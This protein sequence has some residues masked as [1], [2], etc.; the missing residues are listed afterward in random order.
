VRSIQSFFAR[1]SRI[2]RPQERGA[3]AVEMALC[4]L[5]LLTLALG[6][7]E[8]GLLMTT[9][10][11]LN[12]ATRLAGRVASSPCATTGSSTLKGIL[13]DPTIAA[14]TS[15]PDN[16]PRS[17][18]C[19]DS[20]NT[21]FD[22][23]YI[24]RSIESGLG[25]K[26]ADVEKIII[27]K[28]IDN[29]QVGIGRVPQNCLDTDL[30]VQ[31]VCNVYTKDTPLLGGATGTKLL[32]NLDNF[33][34]QSGDQ[35]GALIGQKLV[36]N[37]GCG[38]T[39]P[40]SSKT[41][42]SYPFCPTRT[43]SITVGAGTKNVPVRLRN[44]A[45]P[46]PLGIY[47]KLK[48]QFVTGFFRDTQT[49]SD[50]TVFRL[51]PSPKVN[52]TQKDPCSGS[53]PPPGCA[54]YPQIKVT[55]NSITEGDIPDPTPPNCVEVKVT[56]SPPQT[57]AQSVRLKTVNGTAKAGTDYKTKTVPLTFAANETE[58][59]VCI[60]I[61]GDTKFEPEES[62]DVEID[63]PSAGLL[64]GSGLLQGSL[65]ANIK[66]IDNDAAPTLSI[67]DIAAIDEGDEG[68]FTV[69]LS[70]V[71]DQDTT[72][73]YFTEDGT[74]LLSNNDYDG[75]AAKT[76]TIPAN[77]TSVKIK[78]KANNDAVT[79]DNENFVVKIS[80]PSANAALGSKKD[81]T[82][83]IKDKTIFLNIDN[84]ISINEGQ[85]GTF[86]VKI[87]K[88]SATNVT[89]TWSTADGA[90][91][92]P[93]ANAVAPGDY[94]QVT[95]GTGT[96]TAGSQSTTI[97][98]QTKNDNV[99]ENT[100][101]KFTVTLA[102]PVGAVLGADKTREAKIVDA[103]PDISISSIASLDEGAVG[104]IT[105]SLNKIATVDVYFSYVAE[106]VSA[107][108][109]L[110]Y[111]AIP[112]TG[113]IKIKAGDK[114]ATFTVKAKTDMTVESPEA[115]NIKL[116]NV[117]G[118]GNGTMTGTVTIIDKTPSLSINNITVAEGASGLFTV[119]ITN[120]S[121]TDITFKYNTVNGTAIA[122]GDYDA[123]TTGTGLI[124]AGSFTTTIS[125]KAL[126]DAIVDN[127]EKFTVVL[128]NVVGSAVSDGTGQAT[129]TDKTATISINSI[130]VV[131]GSTAIVTVSLDKASLLPVSFSYKSVDGTAV[132]PGDYDAIT[133]TTYTIPAGPTT[134]SYTFT[135]KANNDFTLDDN[136][137]FT[138]PLSAIT[139]AASGTTTGTV[140]ITDNSPILTVDDVTVDEGG[141]ATFTIKLN[142]ISTSAV[143]F[144]YRTIDG[145]AQA[146]LN[147]YTTRSLTNGS[148]P[149]GQ[150]STTV[151]VVTL[152]DSDVEPAPNEYFDLVL[153]TIV[154]AGNSDPNARG[155]I[156]DKTPVLSIGN[157]T[158]T[159]GG[160][161][162]IRVT[163]SNASTTAVR[164]SY[165]SVDGTATSPADFAAIAA[166]TYTIPAGTLSYD[167]PVNAKPDLINDPNET[168]QVV[169]SSVTG[170]TAGN[171]TGTVTIT[172]NSPILSINNN[173]NDITVPEGG[174]NSFT[175]TLSKPSTSAVTFSYT[176]RNGSALA[177]GDYTTR[178]AT[179]TI[180]AGSTSVTI[181]VS[182]ANDSITDPNEVFYL[183]ITNIVGA[184]SATST[185]TGTA[186]IIDKTSAL[187]VSIGSPAAVAETA[188]V[189]NFPVTLDHASTVPVTVTYSTNNGTAIGGNSCGGTTDFVSASNQTFTI[190]ANQLTF[191]LPITVC[192]DNIYEP[193]ENFTVVISNPVLGGSPLAGT[194]IPT[195][196]TSTG[197]GQIT[198][199]DSLPTITVSSASASEGNNISFNVTLSAPSS[200]SV[201]VALTLT[202]GSA[203]AADYGTLSST[204]V[205]FGAGETSKTV[206]ILARTD[207]VAE[208]T[209]T[210]TVKSTPSGGASTA[211][212]TGTMSIIDVPPV[213][214]PPSTSSTSTTTIATVPPTTPKV[215]STTPTVSSTTLPNSPTSTVNPTS[216]STTRVTTSVPLTDGN[217]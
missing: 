126:P 101:E 135:V 171:L 174:S 2:S 76:G 22:D 170:A 8:Y 122:P 125:V 100:D 79:D 6:G 167:I 75:I 69:T 103:T 139:G 10:H 17:G 29:D 60:D 94:D 158:V 209:E 57:I 182:A 106:D 115:F 54:T 123:V 144:G 151:T 138:I 133:Q 32:A 82:A 215:T 186:T 217:T 5:L 153:S 143:T 81:G 202:P 119:S 90:S 181:S 201:T 117:T 16:R 198:S 141:T 111:E 68:E 4:G 98:V 25:G 211:T 206:T 39:R 47:V 118:A 156:V 136:E 33:Y 110:D 165:K 197:T 99:V 64:D 86:T 35:T 112:L 108:S 169:L 67:N 191:N 26:M 114:T 147:D 116:V 51:E 190:P 163:L 128:S 212:S 65:R 142:K 216:T 205:T 3:A 36:D 30:G 37:F 89:F 71:S 159:E 152:P 184:G 83:T 55:A 161:S 40:A 195:V 204:S 24:L 49:L 200:S 105:V 168:Y 50:W 87:D 73:T 44:I 19:E 80:N 172:E 18:G 140:T 173:V 187:K 92:T 107:T 185:L 162:T 146:G 45:N 214:L 91:P 78:V 95:S 192:N 96:I 166:T 137:R 43:I 179:A 102:S 70:A 188:G 41:L 130:S 42:A 160:T 194:P 196:A 14:P 109:G 12:V 38:N 21:E 113:P 131:E 13:L 15:G 9:K 59:T 72:F 85:K 31:S 66:I 53:N 178:S 150:L 61:V 84:N 56:L 213:T 58:K 124:A 7:G 199:E 127:N 74:A 93:A 207:T 155:F 52:E 157:A 129:I 62:F 189:I 27:Y 48:H 210:F 20:G 63:T 203:T 28:G 97:E 177:P 164:F 193:T 46:T 145:T 1:R 77:Q 134:T 104:T 176:T 88:V 148:I 149:A 180:P 23:F 34:V 208:S 183:D 11:D 175:I 154:G 120:S 121:P 132:A